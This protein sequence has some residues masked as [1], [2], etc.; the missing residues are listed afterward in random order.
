MTCQGLSVAG[1]RQVFA[2]LIPTMSPQNEP[3]PIFGYN[4]IN[5]N[6]P[7][8]SPNRVHGMSKSD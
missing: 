6:L 4:T 1:H 7:N 5:F 8:V 2:A 3:A